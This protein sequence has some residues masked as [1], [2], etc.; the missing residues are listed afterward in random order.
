MEAT[1]VAL[2][3]NRKLQVLQM[4][5]INALWK[6]MAAL[7]PGEGGGPSG[8]NKDTLQGLAE[9]CLSLNKQVEELQTMMKVMHHANP[10]DSVPIATQ[11][12]IIAVHTP[13]GEAKEGF[14][15]HPRLER[16]SN[17]AISQPP[18]EPVEQ[19]A[20]NLASDVIKSL[21]STGSGPDSCTDFN[22]AIMELD[23]NSNFKGTFFFQWR[24]NAFS[25]CDSIGPSTN[26]RKP[27][28]FA[29]LVFLRIF[30]TR[31]FL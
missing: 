9:T 2:E 22:E 27:G 25:G 16:P 20:N 19:Y 13:Q 18:P 31:I 24:S 3:G 5:A 10:C 29:G 7:Q 30:F 17:L 12:E 28:P 14:P 26:Y 4:Q 23:D 21:S 8:E 1:R 6:K 15:Y 11:T